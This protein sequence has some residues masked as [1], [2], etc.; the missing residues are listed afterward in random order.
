MIEWQDTITLE[1]STEVLNVLYNVDLD[2]SGGFFV[3]DSRE[4][5]FRKYDTTG[6]L[7]WFFGQRGKGPA[8]FGPAV[9]AVR[10]AGEPSHVALLDRMGKVAVYDE[11]GDSLVST[12]RLGFSRI[13]DVATSEQGALW[14]ATGLNH[15]DRPETVELFHSVDAYTGAILARVPGPAVV[16]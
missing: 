15:P 12:A 9:R 5:Q 13:Q 4:G 3:S 16:R 6:K 8:E 1:E 11:A 14:V 7:V 2:V 10:L